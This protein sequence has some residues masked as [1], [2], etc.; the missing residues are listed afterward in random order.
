[1][2]RKATG[3]VI[4]PTEGRAWAIRFRAYGKRHYLALGVPEDGWDRERA[5]AELRHVLADVE[6]GIWKPYEPEP[7]E[8]PAE[9]PSFHEFASRWLESRKPELRQRTIKDY[10][11]ALS[12][13][14]LPFF[15][16]HLL[17]EITVAEV[18]RYKVAKV[19]EGKLEAAQINKTLKRLVSDSRS[20]RST[21][22]TCRATQRRRGADGGASRSLRRAGPWVEPEQLMALLDAAPRRHR[23]GARDAGRGGAACG[24]AVRARLARSRPCYGNADRAGVKDARREGGRSICRPG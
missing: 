8:V 2:A 9:V 3:Q 7:V 5:E 23:A 10:Q 11:W 22:G 1:M 13:H 4:E 20:W 12:Y 15:K 18:D 16:D 6:R 14:L 21:T 17:V 19:R 24:G